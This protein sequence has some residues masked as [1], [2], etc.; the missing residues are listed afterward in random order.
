[1]KGPGE[2]R[3]MKRTLLHVIGG[4]GDAAAVS[5]PVRVKELAPRL[6]DALIGVRA[7]VVALCLQK[8][9]GQAFAR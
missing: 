8:V 9:G 7:E 2:L 6:I 1:M 4:G 5:G 3:R